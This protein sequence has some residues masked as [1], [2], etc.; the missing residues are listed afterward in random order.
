MKSFNTLLLASACTLGFAASSSFA[1]DYAVDYTPETVETIERAL[2]LTGV[3]EV[4]GDYSFVDRASGEAV[5]TFKNS[6]DLDDYPE[7]GGSVRVSIP[8]ADR[9][10][11]QIDLDGEIRVFDEDDADNDHYLGSYAGTVHLSYRNP[12][13]YLLGVFGGAGRLDF[14][15]ENLTDF[16]YGG[17]EAQYY[18]DQATL[19]AQ[20]GY[21]GSDD[22]DDNGLDDAWFVRGVGRYFLSDYS[23]AQAEL[24]YFDGKQDFDGK[25]MY[26]VS[27]G[28][29]AEHQFMPV[30]VSLFVAYEGNYFDNHDDAGFSDNGKFVEHSFLVGA[31]YAFGATGL[32]ANDRYGATLDTPS[33]GRWVAAGN[34]ID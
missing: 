3:V 2:M 25:D 9:F 5:G 7:V 22:V 18:L 15:D 28:L 32:K 19:Y 23:M 16:W 10:S 33:F 29:R 6:G 13:D 11:A 21:I 17:V 12:S 20:V 1:A 27:W 8:F 24:A 4:Y 14:V 34:E 31:K 30:P 26:G